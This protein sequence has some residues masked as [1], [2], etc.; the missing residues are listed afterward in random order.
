MALMPQEQFILFVYIVTFV[1]G[2][3]TNSL[4]LY[5][6]S[7]KVHHKPAPI[8]ILLLNLSVSDLI[9]L[10]FL[11]FRMVQVSQGM[12]WVL[13]NLL[14]P[15]SN[16]IFYSTIYISTLFLMGVSVE[17]Y[18]GVAYPVHYKMNRKPMYAVYVSVFFWVIST[19]HCTI[20]YIVQYQKPGNGTQNVSSCYEEFTKEQLNILLPVR[21][22]MF[23]V[24]FCI[25]FLITTFCYIS[26]IRI[27]LSLP[28]ISRRR[29]QRAIGLA[30][31]TL[32]VFILCFCPYNI[33]HVV[34]FVKW[35]S[36]KWRVMTLLLSTFNTCLDPI[37]FY[38]SSSEV[39]NSIRNCIA[40]VL[41]RIRAIGFCK[42]LCPAAC[43]VNEQTESSSNN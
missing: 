15:L 38:F 35:Q 20:V 16:F 7:V 31:G 17:R 2:L 3:P 39:Q 25:P 8:D 26:F 24:L 23:F 14:C 11:P 22:E 6:F 30:L 18:L 36:P 21:F 12:H 42:R 10:L 41:G 27:L 37:I 40:G 33:S 1:T 5:T 4:A 43:T 19:A 13:P 29:K 34:G 9:F 28:N 32:L